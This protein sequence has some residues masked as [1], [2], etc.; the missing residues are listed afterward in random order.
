MNKK[1]DFFGDRVKK[2]R[3][4]RGHSQDSLGKF[5]GMP[6]QS[7]SRIEKG[8]RKVTDA[9]L[10][11]IAEFLEVPPNYLFEDA[12][13]EKMLKRT[14]EPQNKWG[15]DIPEFIDEYIIEKEN[16]I[17]YLIYSEQF[18]FIKANIEQLQN[19]I[20][21]LQLLLKECK[22]KTKKIQ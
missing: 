8:N 11:K 1:Y 14:Y 2:L 18:S 22:E 6:K 19:I 16:Y 20:K 10:E 7:I 9:E 21:T 4:L 17:D 12:F 3:I 5:L 13:I 15:I